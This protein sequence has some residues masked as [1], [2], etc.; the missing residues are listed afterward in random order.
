M[1][2]DGTEKILLKGSHDLWERNRKIVYHKIWNPRACSFYYMETK[3]STKAK[4]GNHD[5]IER[6]DTH[7]GD[8]RKLRHSG[9]GWSGVWNL[10]VV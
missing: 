4:G 1:I 6:Y 9:P 5:V 7:K 10:R 2:F 8:I 3:Y